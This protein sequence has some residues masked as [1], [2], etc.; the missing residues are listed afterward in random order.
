[1]YTSAIF[2]KYYIYLFAHITLDDCPY[3]ICMGFAKLWT[4][5]RKQKIKKKCMP[6]PR[7]EP[8]TPCLSACRSNHST[9]PTG[10]HMSWKLSHFYRLSIK[11]CGNACIKLI[12]VR[13]V[14]ELSGKICISF[15]NIDV[16]YYCLQNF[17]W[18]NQTLINFILSLSPDRELID[19]QQC[20][21]IIQQIVNCQLSR[22]VSEAHWKVRG[23]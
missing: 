4:T 1:M 20:V 2:S 9:T 11:T 23:R 12:L 16:I 5:G 17:V 3:F 15:T 19:S 6:Q 21:K 10:N 18:T 14:L 22:M 8:A 7:I 13:Y